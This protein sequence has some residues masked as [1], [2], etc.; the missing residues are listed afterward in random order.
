MYSEVQLR[1]N[2]PYSVG[3]NFVLHRK[4]HANYM[5]RVTNYMTGVIP[6]HHK[7]SLSLSLVPQRKVGTYINYCVYTNTVR[8][9]TVE[10]LYN[11]HHWVQLHGMY[12]NY[13]MY[14]TV[15]ADILHNTIMQ[16]IKC[17]CKNNMAM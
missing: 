1:S 6:S 11:E 9:S 12:I 10:L 17:M 3:F 14:M 5:T 4:V 16:A 7:S 2:I 8:D 15:R 13:C